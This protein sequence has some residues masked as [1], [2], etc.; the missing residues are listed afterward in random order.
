MIYVS[1]VEIMVKARDALTG[2]LGEVTASWVT[3][4]S[5]SGASPLS[6]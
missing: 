2:E 4:L 5:F 3:A 6:R 1:F